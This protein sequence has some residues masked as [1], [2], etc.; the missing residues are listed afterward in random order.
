MENDCELPPPAK[1][2]KSDS[3]NIS[4]FEQCDETLSAVPGPSHWS[5][6]QIGHGASQ[7]HDSSLSYRFEKVGEKTFKNGVIDRHYRVKFNPDESLEGQ[8]LS[9]LHN[10]L[11][12][13]FDD[14]I[15]QARD[16]LDG[17]DLARVIIHHPKLD[18]NIYFPLR[19]IS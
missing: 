14:V 10:Q 7:V 12:D 5:P 4:S 6:P 18:N 19:Q 16:N 1:K 17:A 11:E 15:D 8:N 2:A 9:S 13:M 3:G